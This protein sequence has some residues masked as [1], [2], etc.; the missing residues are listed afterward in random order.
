L[1]KAENDATH[2]RFLICKHLVRETVDALETIGTKRTLRFFYELRRE[3]TSP[4][5]RIPG[6]H[7]DLSSAASDEGIT[8]SPLDELEGPE[9][10]DTEDITTP[11]S[12][13]PNT[14]DQSITLLRACAEVDTLGR[15]SLFIVFMSH[16]SNCTISGS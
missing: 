16:L 15:V 13:D 8:I 1:K 14:T 6:I 11:S 3:R 5:Y 9:V 10:S 2:T 4:F 7:H 12:S